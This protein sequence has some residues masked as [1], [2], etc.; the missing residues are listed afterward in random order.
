M[1]MDIVHGHLMKTMPA[2]EFKQT[3]LRVLDQVAQTG[4]DVVIT[5]R[6]V[7]VARISPLERAPDQKIAGYMVGTG[8]IVGDGIE[9]A[10]DLDVWGVESA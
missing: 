6:G 7:P 5:K 10:E 4:L 2:G 8:T 9:P 3:C 1:S